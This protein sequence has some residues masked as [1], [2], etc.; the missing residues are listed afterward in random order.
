MLVQKKMR[1]NRDKPTRPK[2]LEFRPS[3][4][5]D[6]CMCHSWL[7]R[8]RASQNIVYDTNICW[9]KK[10]VLLFSPGC[11]IIASTKATQHRQPADSTTGGS[12]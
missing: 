8:A 7:Q 3:T 12:L 10:I 1:R 2:Y 5:I 4:A 6:F 11:K 9:V